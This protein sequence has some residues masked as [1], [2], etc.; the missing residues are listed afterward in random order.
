[1]SKTCP[2]C[3]KS[4]QTTTNYNKH[5]QSK[6]CTKEY[7]CKKC[8]KE[9]STAQALR[10]HNAKQ[11][12]CIPDKVPVID[13]ENTKNMCKYCGKTYANTYSLNRHIKTCNIKDDSSILI[14]LMLQQQKEIKEQ[15]QEL[16]NIIKQNG[17][18]N[19][20]TN[21]NNNLTINNNVQQNMYVNV[22]IC[23]FGKEDL[24]KLNKQDIINLLQGQ[25]GD[26]MTRMID[27]IHANPKYPEFH[28][29]FYDP[30]RKMALVYKQVQNQLSTWVCEDIE[31][32]S[33][34]IADKIKEHIHPLNSPYFNTLAQSKD[35]ETANKI[36]QILC[37]NWNTPET[38]EGTIESLSKVTKNEGF[39]DRVQELDVE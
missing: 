27:Y 39:M 16:I 32:V 9:F 14:D 4:Y 6:A 36:P 12:P 37:A 29:A 2:H 20:I 28:N 25:V 8:K 31:H 24:S 21:N 10:K 18:G 7:N 3:L 17:L 30:T 15:N 11:T 33:K 38:V 1:M 22:T 23:D 35:T 5:V 34:Q 13:N 26:F 19:Q